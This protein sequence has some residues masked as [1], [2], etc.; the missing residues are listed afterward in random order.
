MY[1]F[2]LGHVGNDTVCN[3]EQ[4]EILRTI[5]ILS[6]NSSHVINGGGKISRTVQLN[7][8]DATFVS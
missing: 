1:L 8:T 7:T 5:G 6:R 2:R 4:N 3:D